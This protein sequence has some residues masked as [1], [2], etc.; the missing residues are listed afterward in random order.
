MT[1]MEVSEANIA[2]DM[3]IEAQK[4]AAKSAQRR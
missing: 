2:M 3:M 4:K 1:P